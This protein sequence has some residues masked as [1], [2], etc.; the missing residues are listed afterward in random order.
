M[1]QYASAQPNKLFTTEIKVVMLPL[2][3]KVDAGHQ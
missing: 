1:A 3:L 2:A